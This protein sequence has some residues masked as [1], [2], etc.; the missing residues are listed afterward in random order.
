[1]GRL[2]VTIAVTGVLAASSLS[3]AQTFEGDFAFR[4]LSEPQQRHRIMQSLSDISFTDSAGRRWTVPKGTRIDGASIP[5]VLWTFAGSP[6]VGNYRRASVIPDHYCDLKSEVASEVN[7]M[8]RDAMRADG[9]SKRESQ[10]KYL[11]VSAYTKLTRACGK[12]TDS[13]KTLAQL[14]TFDGAT[15]SGDFME[16]LREWD[17]LP[18]P[19]DTTTMRAAEAIRLGE[20]KN[21]LSFAA[22]LEFERNMT[23]ENYA[24]LER[25]L[26]GEQPSDEEVDLMLLLADVATPD[27]LDAP[28]NK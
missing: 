7:M 9:L 26:E 28:A 13:W 15:K 11:A 10:S 21:P 24:A 14:S 16:L 3:Q 19:D 1:M 17:T 23:E 6:F 12:H 22:L 25:A 2:S 20:I 27:F 18:T 4:W 5:A 8:F